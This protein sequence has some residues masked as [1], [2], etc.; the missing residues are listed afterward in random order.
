MFIILSVNPREG[1]AVFH[2]LRVYELSIRKCRKLKG[3]IFL[4]NMRFEIFSVDDDDQNA[5]AYKK[6]N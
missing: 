2:S 1:I 5:P 3:I 4:K 6:K